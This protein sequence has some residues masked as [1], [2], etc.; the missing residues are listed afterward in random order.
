M[1][2]GIFKPL[3]SRTAVAEIWESERLLAEVFAREDGVR[4]LYLSE[5]AV[6]SGLDWRRF[7]GL[8]PEIEAALDKADEEM[9]EARERLGEL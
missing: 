1:E 6:A 9:R 4:R 8:V 2:L 7:S 5:E 3:G